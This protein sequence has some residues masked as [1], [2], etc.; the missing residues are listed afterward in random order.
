MCIGCVNRDAQEQAKRT[1]K[2]TSDP[3][4]PVVVASLEPREMVRSVEVTGSITTPEDVTVGAVTAGRITSVLVRDG[5]PVRAGQVIARQETQDLTARVQQARSAVDAARSALQ[6]A[7]NQALIGPQRSAAAVRSA[8]AQLTS[9]RAGLLKAQNGARPEEKAQAQANVDRAKSDLETA[10]A[11][12]ER[13]KKLY[14]ERAIAKAQLEQSE[15][16]YSS[17]LSAFENALQTQ[18]ITENATRS[19]DLVAAQQAVRSAEEQVRMARSEQ[20]LDVQFAE[21]VRGAQA[22]LRSAQESLGV[23]QKALSDA[24]IRAPFSGKI[25]GNPL[26]VG[27]MAAPG[28]PVARIVNAKASYFEAEVPESTVSQIQQG[29]SVDITVDALPQTKLT[30]RVVAITPSASKVARLYNVR[31]Q[32]LENVPGLKAGMFARGN[33]VLG[34]VSNVPAVPAT[35]LL[36]DG[37]NTSVFVV[38]GD[39]AKKVS[40]QTGLSS[41]EWVQIDGVE[42]GAEV[43]VKGQ[44]KLIDGAPVRVESEAELKASASS[45]APKG[46]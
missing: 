3:T 32:I 38:E 30:G 17:A 8:E 13:S 4:V 35:A 22:N 2:L 41:G 15:N 25:S 7:K 39:K 11:G 26:Q 37:Q 44:S 12:L 28:T 24:V 20:S 9:A 5:D 10:K 43:V 23:A 27:A 42:P 19:E 18:R 16:A 6:Q 40:V 31:I 33:L 46:E 36:R 29:A 1:E 34:R 45:E 21:Q 14:A